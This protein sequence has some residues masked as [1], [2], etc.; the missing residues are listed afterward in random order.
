MSDAGKCL[1]YDDLDEGTSWTT[2]GRTITEAD[3]INFAGFSGD[4]NELHTNVEYANN[5]AFGKR[6]AH[7]M[8]GLA[9]STGLTQQ[10]DLYNQAIIAFLGLDWK[11]T[12][13][14]F[15]GDTI[16]VVQSV[17][18]K[19]ETKKP[20]RGIVVFESKVINQRGEVVQQGERT[21]MLK[22]KG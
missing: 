13:P 16:H 11:F 14:I 19:R 3:I 17:K 15:I 10:P 20:G 21:I 18:S 22:M 9:V 4:Y 6:I 2:K 5:T 1:Y 8:L 7:G 12:G